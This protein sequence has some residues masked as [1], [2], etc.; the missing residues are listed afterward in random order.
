MSVSVGVRVALSQ[1]AIADWLICK[2]SA[3]WAWLRRTALRASRRRTPSSRWR[4]SLI[5]QPDIAACFRFELETDRLRTHR[6][7]HRMGSPRCHHGGAL[8]RRD[9]VDDGTRFDGYRRAS[10]SLAGGARV[11]IIVTAS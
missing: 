9:S 5:G 2:R 8:L 4:G 7:R 3:S 10:L 6:N 1:L 11:A